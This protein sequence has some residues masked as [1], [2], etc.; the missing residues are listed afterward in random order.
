MDSLVTPLHV[1]RRLKLERDG[2]ISEFRAKHLSEGT[3]N[4]T[5]KA[6]LNMFSNDDKKKDIV[7]ETF[8]DG[9]IYEG[10]V[11]IDNVRSGKGRGC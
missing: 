7:S 5:L 6:F 4:G 3:T 11:N 1:E 2:V 8:E 10:S 9:S